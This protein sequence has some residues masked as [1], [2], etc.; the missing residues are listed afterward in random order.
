MNHNYEDIKNVFR[1][2]KNS[3]GKIK[4]FLIID[5]IFAI[6]LTLLAFVYNEESYFAAKF[7]CIL[8]IIISFLIAVAILLEQK[9]N[10]TYTILK[11]KKKN[12]ENYLI[13]RYGFELENDLM[14]KRVDKIYY[15]LEYNFGVVQADLNRKS[16]L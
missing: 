10:K 5:G 11:S 12:I 16:I 2:E 4:K 14:T 15:T 8:F 7:F 9:A 6:I 1:Y 3:K 13:D